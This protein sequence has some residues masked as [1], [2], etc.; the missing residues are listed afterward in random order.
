MRVMKWCEL[1]NSPY[2]VVMPHNLFLHSGLVLS[3]SFKMGER[4][5][6]AALKY[7]VAESAIGRVVQVETS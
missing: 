3:R 5:L 7:N 4:S 2:A 6:R 1:S